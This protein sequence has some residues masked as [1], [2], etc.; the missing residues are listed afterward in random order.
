[1]DV[2]VM[3]N[4][5][6]HVIKKKSPTI[7]GVAAM[8]GVV[9]TAYLASKASVQASRIIEKEEARVGA[10]AGTKARVKEYT[11]LVW[12]L[13]IPTVASGAVTIGCIAGSTKISK[14]RISAAQAAFVLSERAYSEYRD[15]VIQE[16][17][18]RKDQA[19]RDE[20]AEDRVKK[21]PPPSADILVVG[22]GNVL[23]CELYTGRYFP[24]DMETLRRTANDLN[25]HLLKHDRASLE[26]WH[27][28]IGL[29]PTT[30]AGDLGWHSDRLM[31]LVFTTVLTEDGRPALAFDYNYVRPLYEGIM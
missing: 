15:K 20:I 30:L 25:A 19:I 24:S 4:R 26:D 12:K 18:Q 7:L 2:K 3:L 27:D 8:G 21:T 17:G 14:R 1:M 10:I 28:M 11:P 13:Y 16:Y 5:A 22:P 6:K 29:S 23:C 31:E 9:A